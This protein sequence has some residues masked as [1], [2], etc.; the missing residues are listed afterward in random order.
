MGFAFIVS[1]WV[2]A[3]S[4]D[5]FDSVGT[6]FQVDTFAGLF[7][8]AVMDYTDMVQLIKEGECRQNIL[9]ILD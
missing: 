8:T 1:N 6:L 4:Y 9:D 2:V 3:N 7:R 5:N